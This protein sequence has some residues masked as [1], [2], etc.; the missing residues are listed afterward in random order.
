ML[1]KLPYFLFIFFIAAAT[2]SAYTVV[3]KNGKMMNG[4][5][6]SETEQSILFKDDAGVQYSLKKAN[7]DLDKMKEANA[8]K[9]EA[10]PPIET[11]VTTTEA[12]KKK[13]RVYTKEDVDSLRS[14]Y[15]ELSLGEPVENAEDFEGGVLKPSAYG[16]RIQQGAEAIS[17][18]MAGLIELRDGVATAWEVA[19]STG[20]SPVE[21]VNAVLGT[22]KAAATMK[23]VS[24]DL[25]ILG[26][27]QESMSNPPDKFKEGYQLYVQALTALS[28]FQKTIREWNR[29]NNVNI[30]RSS[31][32]QLETQITT[33]VAKIPVTMEEPQT[34]PAKNPDQE[35]PE[36]QQPPNQ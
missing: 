24:D 22:E 5:L 10:P 13:A 14:K 33:S 29:V 2:A 15:P 35:K 7:L 34:E 30:F 36:D 27:W 3:L 1:K 19:A 21:A 18:N 9:M 26:R 12:P 20:K 28:D 25:M 4:T 16:K 32:A 31:L 11:P 23:S 8:P 6:I 17:S